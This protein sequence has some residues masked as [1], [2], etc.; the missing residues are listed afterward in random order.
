M[1][2]KIL[3]LQK[4]I[5]LRKATWKELLSK[6][7]ALKTRS[8]DLT[9]AIEEAETEDD[10]TLVEEEVTKHEKEKDDHD[11]AKTALEEEIRN[12]ETELSDLE[13]KEPEKRGQQSEPQAPTQTRGT[14]TFVGGTENMKFSKTQQRAAI[15]ATINQPEVRAFYEQLR[16][17]V[18]NKRALSGVNLVIPTVVLDRI[19]PLIGEA[20]KL[21]SEVE[22]IQLNGEGRAIVD[23][24]IPEAIWTEMKDAVEEIEDAF[25]AVEIDGYKVGG[26]IPVANAFLEDSMIDLAVHIENRIARSIG[27]A[28]DKA[29]LRGTGAAGKQP[30]GIIPAVTGTK[31]VS[32]SKLGTLLSYLGDVDAGEEDESEVIAVMTRQTYFKHIMPQTVVNTADGRQV[33]ASVTN[34]NIAG[35][36]VKFVS[37][38]PANAVLFGAFKKYVL[39]ERKGVQ[40]A[41][42]TEVRFIEDQTVFKGTARYDGKPAKKEAF[43]LIELSDVEQPAGA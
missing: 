36:R 27:K 7:E 22:V 39:G 5:E 28:L 42:S 14:N 15:Q 31:K 25:N 17:A 1:A 21:Y 9:K 10:L 34:P 11:N 13:N 6:D 33:V 18:M 16:D 35:L 43:Q 26:F 40:V 20:S 41:S 30:E 37:Y 4:K 12:L 38:M 19:Q 32:T 23:G 29:I 24:E 2:L 3:K 8:A